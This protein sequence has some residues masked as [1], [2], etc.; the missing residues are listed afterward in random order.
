LSP[1]RIVLRRLRSRGSI[2]AGAARAVVPSAVALLG[3]AALLPLRPAGSG[4]V[5][6]APP[7]QPAGTAADGRRASGNPWQKIERGLELGTFP[8]LQPAEWGDS[9]IR[10][11][12]I[13]PARFE[14]RLL[15]ASAPGQG[16][17]LPAKEWC[18]R[19][20]LVAAINASMYRT[21][22][23]T[24]VSLMR[25]G[26]HVNNP[27][28]SKDKSI[29]AFDPRVGGVPPVAIL[30][31]ECD[32]FNTLKRR[33]QSLVQSIR[34]ISCKGENVWSPQPRMWSTAAIGTDHKGRILFI[35][36]RSP[37]STHD[38]I[39]M[40]Q[41]LPLNLTRAMYSEGGTEAQLYVRGPDRDYEF[42]GATGTSN[43]KE[44]QIQLAWP[45][46]NVVGIARKGAG[47]R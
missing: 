44:S 29:L 1:V 41:A 40:L 10:V 45:I 35:H 27:S 24:S 23:R 39:E 12:R 20:G 25:T 9:R 14:L 15:N 34:M 18:R 31:R 4:L 6:A 26:D 19:N 5:L 28:L 36:V 17:P 8:A 3:L 43:G 47:S 42:L 32:D 2:P 16:R 38:L 33:Y 11:L 22:Y 21:D 30:D 13:D 46:P 7:S 37:Y